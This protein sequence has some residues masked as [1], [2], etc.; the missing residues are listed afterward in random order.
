MNNNNN[1]V[2]A[3]DAHWAR[4]ARTRGYDSVQIEHGPDGFP[5]ILITTEPCLSQPEAIK[6]C[7]P[8]ELRTGENATMKCRCS[9]R[10]SDLLNCD[11][12]YV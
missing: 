12:N 4:I 8:I 7:P 9:D 6:T 11:D 10:R 5:E 2:T 3:A 1:N